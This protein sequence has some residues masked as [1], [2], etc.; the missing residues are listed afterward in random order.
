MKNSEVN[1]EYTAQLMHGYEWKEPMLY[2][3]ALLN[4]D[5]TPM[6]FVVAVLEKFFFMDRHQA[7]ETML[8]AHIKGKA[9][10]GCFSKD[11]AES[12]ITQVE[13][14][15]TINEHPLVLTMEAI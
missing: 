9:I 15:A 4:D 6:E 10:C 5:F 8:E 14:Y 12:K 3:V 2:Q 1:K 13:D 11:I 7:S